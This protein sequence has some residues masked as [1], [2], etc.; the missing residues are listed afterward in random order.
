MCKRR[1]SHRWTEW[2]GLSATA[3]PL[4]RS[5]SSAPAAAA[6]E[7]HR[8]AQIRCPNHFPKRSRSAASPESISS[9]LSI[10]TA[11]V[12]RRSPNTYLFRYYLWFVI[13]AVDKVSCCG[14]PVAGLLYTQLMMKNARVQF[15]AENVKS[16]TVLIIMLT[17]DSFISYTLFETLWALRHLNRGVTWIWSAEWM[18]DGGKLSNNRGTDAQSCVLVWKWDRKGVTL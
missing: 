9:A 18:V 2:L 4:S 1:L 8:V 13:V 14:G 6:A 7:L 16:I 5:S 10:C 11:P 15:V 17:T 12:F 3:F